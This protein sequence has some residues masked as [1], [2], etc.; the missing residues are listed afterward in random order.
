M[1]KTGLMMP[2][3]NRALRQKAGSPGW[4]LCI[5]AG[6]SYPMFP[7]WYSLVSDLVAQDIGQDKAKDI[8][9]G[10]S[11]G[12]GLDALVQAARDRLSLPPD[13]FAKLLS[14]QLY[15]N[16]K[17]KLTKT[18]WTTFR[19]GLASFHPGDLTPASWREFE[20]TMASYFP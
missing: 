17:G 6:T 18:E 5:G 1:A 19:R 2:N 15:A 3:A 13:K 8:M 10:L 9:P 14:D 4:T 11:T 7:N 16:I 12:F 20:A